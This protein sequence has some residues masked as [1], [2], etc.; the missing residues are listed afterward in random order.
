M[1]ELKLLMAKVDQPTMT[2]EKYVN[3]DTHEQEYSES[4]DETPTLRV[5]T[6]KMADTALDDV[7][8]TKIIH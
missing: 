7:I 3:I 1:H 6:T 5:I 2:A 4:D 8:N